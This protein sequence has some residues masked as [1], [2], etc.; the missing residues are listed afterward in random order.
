MK[1]YVL[2][3]I[4]RLKETRTVPSTDPASQGC[5]NRT[6][7]KMRWTTNNHPSNAT[8]FITQSYKALKEKDLSAAKLY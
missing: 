2:L 4:L 5:H 6:E 7:T 3:F 8:D 1:G